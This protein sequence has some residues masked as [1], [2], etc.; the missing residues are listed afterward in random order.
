VRARYQKTAPGRYR[1]QV[2]HPARPGKRLSLRAS[3]PGEMVARLAYVEELR[4]DVSLGMR[5][6]ADVDRKLASLT[7]P[8]PRALTADQLCETWRAGLR[9]DARPK[10]LSVWRRQLQPSIGG[11]QW[12]ELDAARMRAWEAWAIG[13]GY[14]PK[15]I[16]AAFS[17]VSAAF[18]LACEAGHIDAMPWGRWHPRKAVARRRREAAR[19]LAELEAIIRAARELDPRSDLADRIIVIALCGLRQGEA[20]ALGWDDLARGELRVRHNAIDGWQVLH[21]EW[22]RPQDPPKGREPE[23]IAL[24]PDAIEALERQRERQRVRGVYRPDGPVFPVWRGTRAGE[25]RHMYACIDTAIF[26]RVV[27]AA[28]VPNPAAWDVHSLRHSNATLEGASGA[29]PRDTQRRTRHA[30]MAQLAHYA[31]GSRELPASKIP[32]LTPV[33]ITEKKEPTE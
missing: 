13:Q 11:A 12:W 28:G 9:I 15:T 32:R 27:E 26:R 20:S 25:W 6:P 5:A 22:D 7:K 23:S 24:H 16:A 33:T 4:R 17:Q 29:D 19:T 21:P 31:H 8:D 1:A 10:A 18:A 30:T 2:T 3:S 14:A